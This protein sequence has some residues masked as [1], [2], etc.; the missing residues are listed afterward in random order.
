M[1]DGPSLGVR[2]YGTEQPRATPR[3]LRAG[4]LSAELDAGNLRHVRIGGVEAIRAVSYIVRDRDWGTYEPEISELE[5]NESDDRFELSYVASVVAGERIFRYAAT[6]VGTPDGLTFAARGES[7]TGFETNRTGFVVLHPIAGVAGEP[8]RIERVD[9][10]VEDGAFPE[11]VDPLQPMMELRALTHEPAPGV[12][13]ECRMEGDTYEM[14]DQRNWTD[15][16]YKTYVRPLARPWP[17]EIPAGEPLEQRVVL[18]VTGEASDGDAAA[19]DVSLELGPAGAAL[20]AFGIGLDGGDPAPDDAGV[21]ALVGLGIAHALVRHDPRRGDGAGSLD[22]LGALAGRIGATPRLEAVVVD[23]NGHAAELD[24]LADAVRGTGRDFETV[25]VSPA[26]DTKGTLPG[27]EWPPAPPLDALYARARAAFPDS[28]IGGGTFAFF[29]ELNRKR[30]P[31]EPLDAVC[32]TTSALVH[33]GDDATAME[34]LEA[35]PAVV[36]TARTIADGVPLSIGPSA[37]GMRI[38]PYGDAPAENPDN[39]RQAMNRADP[40]QRGLFGAAWLVG[41][42]AAAAVDGVE[43]IVIGAATGARGVVHAR[44]ADPAPWY[45]EA[46]GVYPQYHVL[47]ALAAWRGRPRRAL[48]SSRPDAVAA[49]AC[50]AGDGADGG[51]GGSVEL[52]VANLTA[53]PV[54]VTFPGAATR[55]RTLDADAFARAASTPTF[56]DLDGPDDSNEGPG[57]GTLSLDAFAVARVRLAPAD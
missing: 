11:A 49:I 22:A 46:G 32:F 56:L 36:A 28:R 14:E 17:Y 52:L 6:I 3:V 41:H 26:A 8:V 43:S 16:S 27:S 13:V 1:N 21:E 45:D 54:E 38:N 44:G 24:G 18:S 39:V 55:A 23:V 53:S 34:N 20:P 33:A 12:S 51:A 50:D 57:G 7:P 4:A 48:A 25:F 30:P 40:R 37:I 29:T 31:T 15:A 9:G 42:A 2:L 35:V 19:N 5:V 10:D 47:R